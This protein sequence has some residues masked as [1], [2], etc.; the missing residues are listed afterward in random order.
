[1]SSQVLALTNGLDE[2]LE[3]NEQLLRALAADYKVDEEPHL[4][5]FV[6]P[7]DRDEPRQRL[8]HYREGYTVDLCRPYVEA[9]SGLALDPFCGFG[10]SLI[11]A[12]EAGLPVVGA[13]VNPLAA[14]VARAKTASYSDKSL[15]ALSSL[16]CRLKKLEVGADESPS[17]PLRILP[18]LFDHEVLQALNRFKHHILLEPDELARNA[19]FACW[20]S[21]LEVVSNVYREGNG[22]KYRNRVRRKNVYTSIPMTEW[23]AENLPTDKHAFVRDTLIASIEKAE[24]DFSFLNQGPDPV[25]LEADAR[26]LSSHIEPNS[27][28]L[29]IFSPPYCNCFNYIKAYKLELWMGGFLTSYEDIRRLTGRGIVSRVEGLLQMRP[30]APTKEVEGLAQLIGEANLWSSALPDVVRGYFSDMAGFLRRLRHF[31]A[32]QGKVVIVVGNSALG[33][34]LIPTD[35][36]LCSLAEAVGFRVEN[37]KVARHLTTSSQQ[38]VRLEPVR[39]FLRETL[40]ELQ[41]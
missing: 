19:A 22:V 11:A 25:V 16:K 33:G 39:E 24:Q 9:A 34:V 1:M 18:K 3:K 4:A 40:I 29:A 30:I 5:P 13:D 23:I 36:L 12:K 17:P 41:A 31:C 38:K 8:F 27:V 14:F 32:P 37:L 2:R 15:S 28:S 21:V 10:S 20:L 7:S 26:S 6:R 35:L